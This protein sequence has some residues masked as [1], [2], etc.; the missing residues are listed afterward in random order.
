MSLNAWR[1][2]EGA[3]LQHTIASRYPDEFVFRMDIKRARGTGSLTSCWNRRHL[4]LAHERSS[5][6]EALTGRAGHSMSLVESRSGREAWNVRTSI[7]FLVAVERA[8]CQGTAR[9]LGAAR[10]T[11]AVV[12]CETNDD[13]LSE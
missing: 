13:R 2:G 5:N 9:R 10:P 7:S 1:A 6:D 4:A 12:A 3:V 8:Y 11:I